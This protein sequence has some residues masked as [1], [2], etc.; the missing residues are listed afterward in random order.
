MRAL[1]RESVLAVDTE[2]ASFHRHLNRIYLIQV[3]TRT[4]TAI[5][6]PLAVSQLGELG[7]LLADPA[8][9]VVFHDADYDLRLFDREY[10]FRVRSLFDTRIAAELLNEPGLSLAALLHRYLGVQVDKR[11]QRADWSKRPLSAEMLAYAG[12]DTQHLVALRDLLA[13]RL[14]AAGRTGWAKEEFALLEGVRW[15]PEADREPAFLRIKGAKA[16]TPRRLAI[17]REVHGWRA[18]VAAR[19]DRAEFRI[20]GNDALLAIASAAPD[21]IEALAAIKGVGRE[22]LQR[23]GKAILAAVRRGLRT[24]DKALP[25]LERPPRRTREPEVEARVSRLKAARTRIASRLGLAPG[26]VC[27]NSLLEM[28]AREHPRDLPTLAGIDGM[29]RWQVEAFGEE[30]LESLKTP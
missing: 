13:E 1:R 8:I 19:L 14:E 15:T 16:L 9:E 28:I 26:V 18:S 3:S 17:L 6:D 24:P 25:H 2:A 20:L 11:L 30:L 29:R 4:E 5:V 23:R 27:P 7:A 21:T 12:G 22:T 10:G